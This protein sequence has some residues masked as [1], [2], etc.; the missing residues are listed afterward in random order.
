VSTIETA[1]AFLV[2]AFSIVVPILAII[3]IA[4]LV[5]GMFYTS[6]QMFRK[7]FAR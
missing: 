3:L 4:V 6:R 2:F 1:A 5:G 7:L